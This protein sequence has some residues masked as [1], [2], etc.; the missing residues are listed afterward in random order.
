LGAGHTGNY[1]RVAIAKTPNS[2]P[3]F[4]SDVLATNIPCTNT[5]AQGTYTVSFNKV[6]PGLYYVQW[7]WYAVG[8]T[9][10]SCFE[11]AIS[12]PDVTV[13]ALSYGGTNNFGPA[14]LSEDIPINFNITVPAGSIQLDPTSNLPEQ[15]L[16][17]KLNNSISSIASLNAT[18]STAFIPS[19]YQDGY[20]TSIAPG[21]VSYINLCAVKTNYVYVSMFPEIN[22]TYTY[23]TTN[24]LY[25]SWLDYLGAQSQPISLDG[26]GFLVY[27]T[28]ATST[29]DVPKR[30]QLDGR[31]GN[32][33]LMYYS[34]CNAQY[35]LPFDPV[36]CLEVQSQIQNGQNN[37]DQTQYYFVVTD[38]AWYGKISI[39]QGVCGSAASIFVSLMLTFVVLLF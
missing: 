36:G 13:N 28:Q 24:T 4:D 30:I 27:W 10:Y 3:A 26:S 37:N 5:G 25:T 22:G 23:S 15:Y 32:A 2:G 29:P 33:Y 31:G 18:A 6:P 11:V 12:N 1:C 38:A 34:S 17:I 8:S 19:T 9:W 21:A 39:Q 16:L 7:I 14:E 20:Y 35:T